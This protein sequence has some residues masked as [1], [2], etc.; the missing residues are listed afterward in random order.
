MT[1]HKMPISWHKKNLKN[2]KLSLERKLNELKILQ[3]EIDDLRHAYTK[4]NA[5]IFKAKKL[6]LSEFDV[7]QANMNNQ[8]TINDI[9]GNNL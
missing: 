8:L 7:N 1:L 4:L 2:R 9:V 5:Q 3:K 6:K